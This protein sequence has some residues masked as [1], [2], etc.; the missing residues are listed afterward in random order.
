MQVSQANLNI[1]FNANT[2]QRG[3]RYFS[4]GRVQNLVCETEGMSIQ[5]MRAQVAGSR[6]CHSLCPLVEPRS[7]TAS[8]RPGLENR[9][10][11]AGIRLPAD[12]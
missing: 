11:Q 2:L 12:S 6:L 4:Q 10:G 3:K 8:H 1:N 5:V 7:R 9:P